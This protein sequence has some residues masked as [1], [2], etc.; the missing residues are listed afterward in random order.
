MAVFEVLGHNEKEIRK[1]FA[2]YFEA[3]SFGV[4]PHGG[5]AAGIE[6]F[7]AIVLN[8]PSIREVIAFPK[9]GDGRDLMMNIP[10]EVAKEQLKELHIKIESKK[11]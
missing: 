11:K 5:I 4:P 9:T 7:L 8:E 10:S 3:F 6:R 2:H 1:N